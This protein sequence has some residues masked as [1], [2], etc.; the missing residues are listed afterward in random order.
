MEP[1]R[2]LILVRLT[3]EDDV[4]HPTDAKPPM[5]QLA[6]TG[7][8]FSFWEDDGEDIYTDSDGEPVPCEGDSGRQGDE[9]AR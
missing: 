6:T 3:H 1:T 8:A 2:V 4:I 7:D 5:M 9:R